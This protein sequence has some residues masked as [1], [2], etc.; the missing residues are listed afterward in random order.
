MLTICIYVQLSA[1]LLWNYLLD[2]LLILCIL[3]LIFVLKPV[4]MLF[5]DTIQDNV[6][7]AYGHVDEGNEQ[8]IQ[9]SKYQVFVRHYLCE[10]FVLR[11][12][13]QM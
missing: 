9:A 7:T 6:E 3:S 4:F 12:V 2:G 11:E 13:V 10:S 5:A 8:L 1:L